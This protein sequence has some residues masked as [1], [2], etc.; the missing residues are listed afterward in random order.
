[1][2]GTIEKG[3]LNFKDLYLGKYYVQEISAP[4]SNAY[5]L[6]QT[7]Y[8]VDLA[9]E[10]QDVEIVQKN[11]TVLE[12]IKKQA[13]QLTKI[14]DDGSQTETEL[15]EGAGFKVYLI[16]ELSK[17]KDGTLKPSN[18]TEYAPQDF[19]G[20]DFSKEETA[21]YY[22]NGEKIQTEEMF[23]DKKGYLC[24]PELPYGK[25]VCIESTIPENVEGIQPFLV[26]IDEG[27]REPQTWRVFNDRPMQFYFKIIKKDAQ[28]ELPILKNSAHYKIYDVEKKKYV[29]MKVRYPKPETIDVFETNEEGYLLTPE[30]LK[31]GTYRNCLYRPDLNRH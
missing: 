20:Y 14:S 11:V 30:P 23:T 24:S 15:L 10:G 4:P 8:P 16:S 28:T 13:F 26:T 3:V 29:T 5:L 21:S 12:T 7:K 2:Q 31:M 1:M 22:E 19:I 18:G 27:S 17:V 25:Y 9:Y 6:D